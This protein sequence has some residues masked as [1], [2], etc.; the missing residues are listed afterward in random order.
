MTARG[1][2]LVTGGGARSKA[3]LGFLTVVEDGQLGA[4]G[5]YLVL[6]SAG[7]PLEFHCTTPVKANR[8]QEILYGPTLR[9]YLYGEQ[10]GATLVAKSAAAP[11]LLCVDRAELLAVRPLVSS[12]SLLIVAA[13]DDGHAAAMP[14]RIDSPHVQGSA[15]RLVWSQV[16]R[17]RV[18]VCGDFSADREAAE[19]QLGALGDFD[20]GEPFGRIREAIEEA[21]RG[22]R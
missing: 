4:I 14:R 8:A 3:T 9:P 11:Q 19:A 7:R 5:G 22:S 13:E 1:A 16:G 20:L 6:T 18:G 21:Q 12:P 15:P 17:W 2:E 10:I